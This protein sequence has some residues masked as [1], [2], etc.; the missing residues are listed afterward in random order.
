MTDDIRVILAAD[1]AIAV[2][3]ADRGPTGPTGPPGPQG[4]PGPTGPTGPTGDTGATGSTGPAGSTGPQGVPGPTGPD[5]PQGI[6]GVTGA[7]FP[8]V[9]TASA[10]PAAA[11]N[12]GKAYWV[13]DTALIVVSDGTRWRTAYGDTGWRSITEWTAAG[14]VTGQP[15]PTNVTPT[16]GSAG[17]MWLAR[18][19]S[20]VA[21]RVVNITAAGGPAAVLMDPLAV[22]FR[23]VTNI[24]VPFVVQRAGA[25]ILS[26]VGTLSS[27][28]RIGLLPSMASNDTV[29]RVEV[30]WRTNDAWPTA[31]PGTPALAP[32]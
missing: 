4:V 26:T 17:Q 18:T 7:A 25:N 21:L 29:N 16:P 2:R 8:S 1:P 15:L 28:G 13:T 14:V 32:G 12:A 9:A 23:P 5:G 24:Q 31:L 3:I 30:T 19:G 6:P 11:A 22:G 10:L 20:T 27:G